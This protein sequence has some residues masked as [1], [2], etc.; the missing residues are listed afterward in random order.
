VAVETDDERDNRLA[1]DWI[2]YA[3]RWARRSC[4]WP[5]DWEQIA[6]DGLNAAIQTN[7]AGPI[8]PVDHLI[9]HLRSERIK[10]I[11]YHRA[12]KRAG[13]VPLAEGS[14]GE[15]PAA[16]QDPTAGLLIRDECGR[17]LGLLTPGELRAAV[18]LMAGEPGSN[19][20][21][22]SLSNARKRLRAAINESGD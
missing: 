20:D 10:A 14:I 13:T 9:H 16:E 5:I 4:R 21:R 17:L 1:G 8:L 3:R 6:L 7:E 11:R 12:T 2:G 19:S 15:I 18:R 22:A